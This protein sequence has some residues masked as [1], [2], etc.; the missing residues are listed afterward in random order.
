ML[1][2]WSK[3]RVRVPDTRAPITPAILEK[4]N[5][6]WGFICTDVYEATLLKASNLITFYGGLRISEAVAGS[7]ANTSCHCKYSGE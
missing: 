6:Q 5:Q 1:G 4:L 2:G 7:K 3:E